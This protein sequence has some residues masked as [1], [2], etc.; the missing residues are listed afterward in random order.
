MSLPE[1]FADDVVFRPYWWDAAPPARAEPPLLP[2]N[3]DVA[4][5]GSGFT[6]LAC[7]LALARAGRS[8]VVLESGVAGAGAST[9]NGGQVGSGNQKFKVSRLIRMFGAERAGALLRD[10]VAMLEFF[11]DTVAREAIDCSFV[12]CGRFRG[13]AQPAHYETM[14]RDMEELRR[15]AGVE[16]FMVPRAEQHAEIGSDLYHGG[17]VLPHDATVHPGLFHAGLLARV[18]EAGARVQPFT[19]VTGVVRERERVLVKT[20]RGD[21]G[22]AEVVIASN[23]YTGAAL[24]A[25]HRRIVAPASAIIATEPLSPAL[26]DTLLPKR[27]AMGETRRVFNYFRASPNGERVLLGGRINHLRS[28]DDARA[29]LH[30]QR[31]LVTVFPQLAGVKITHCWAGYL[32]YTRDEFPHI[33]GEDRVWH[34]L[35][36]CGTGVSRSTWFGHKLALKM[37][38]SKDGR[39][40]FDELAF[41]PF[42]LP[43]IARRMVPLVAAAY[44]LQDRLLR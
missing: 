40:A 31:E 1:C 13:C 4:I 3:V 29:Y 8:V 17:G 11:A 32:G 26:M 44:R 9:R 33:G 19:A 35:G 38:G 36:Y 24:P 27:R 23:G 25:F 16:F 2:R 6:G 22:S 20:T 12:R 28:A 43:F 10:G 34:A 7:A 18:R 30:L 14:A 42:P 41:R 15:F 39:T 21:I 5:V 37:L